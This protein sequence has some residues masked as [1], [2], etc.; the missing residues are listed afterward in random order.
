MN[1]KE[2]NEIYDVAKDILLGNICFGDNYAVTRF[3]DMYIDDICRD[4]EE[5]ADEFWNNSDVELA[6]QRVIAK[7][8]EIED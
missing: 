6:I 7:K 1:E 8:L 3:L 5:T 2:K 4:V